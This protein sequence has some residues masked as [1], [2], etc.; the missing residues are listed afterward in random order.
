MTKSPDEL[1]QWQR[2][3]ATTKAKEVI[4]ALMYKL[5]SNYDEGKPFKWTFPDTI[6]TMKEVVKELVV[7][8]MEAQGWKMKKE[9]G[10]SYTISKGS[11][12]ASSGEDWY[13]TVKIAGENSGI[14]LLVV[15][16]NPEMETGYDIITSSDE[17][18]LDHHPDNWH[19]HV[20]GDDVHVLHEDSGWTWIGRIHGEATPAEVQALELLKI[21]HDGGKPKAA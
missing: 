12:S 8:A 18:G 7:E 16:T 15:K 4:Q 14:S 17:G 13:G 5:Q 21:H 10:R 3:V 11:A 19:K 1:Y 20:A 2:S 6:S 9:K